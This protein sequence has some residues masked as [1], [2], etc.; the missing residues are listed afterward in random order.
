MKR[1]TSI[2]LAASIALGATGVGTAVFS[3]FMATANPFGGSEATDLDPARDDTAATY[4]GSDG[5]GPVFACQ[6][7]VADGCVDV[8]PGACDVISAD[9]GVVRFGK[10]GVCTPS[11]A[12]GNTSLGNGTVSVT[13]GAFVGSNSYLQLNNTSLVTGIL[14][15]AVTVDIPS[16]SANSCDLVT[17]T[18]A[19]VEA[20]DLVLFTP[21]FA[22]GV[23][24]VVTAHARVT[25]AATDEVTFEA[26]NTSGGAEDPASGSFL[27]LVMRK[28]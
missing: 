1:S 9:S 17:A 2:A 11:V 22:L 21:N 14:V 28:Q 12:V 13:N 26:C 25:N 3:S 23:D 18:V 19:G 27:F 8:G 7:E 5:T 6:N 4:T 24:D 10:T 15:V 16:I 20:N